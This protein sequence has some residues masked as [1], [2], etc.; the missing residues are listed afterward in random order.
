MTR[1]FDGRVG[2]LRTS[3]DRIGTYVVCFVDASGHRTSKT[4]TSGAKA[5]GIAWGLIC[6]PVIVGNTIVGVARRRPPTPEM[7]L[8]G[9]VVATI[10]ADGRQLTEGELNKLNLAGASMHRVRQV[11]TANRIARLDAKLAAIKPRPIKPTLDLGDE[12]P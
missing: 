4:T 6:Q 7:A 10:V 5:F 1:N 12:E 9:R 2:Y 3:P 11:E 8:S